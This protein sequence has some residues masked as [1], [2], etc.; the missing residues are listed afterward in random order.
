[1][2]CK[3]LIGKL[4][5]L[6]VSEETMHIQLL[7]GEQKEFDLM[8]KENLNFKIKLK[9]QKPPLLLIMKYPDIERNY[10][11]IITSFSVRVPTMEN[12]DEIFINVNQFFFTY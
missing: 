8:K 10:L 5:K 1:M 2:E 9:D 12:Y 6:V 7:N 3:Y 11:T 4:S